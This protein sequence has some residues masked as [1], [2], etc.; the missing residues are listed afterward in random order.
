MISFAKSLL[1][2]TLLT[3]IVSMFIGSS[4]SRGGVLYVHYVSYDGYSA[5]WSWPLFIAGTGL[6][7]V[8]YFVME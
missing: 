6:A 8:I 7:W 3:W 5:Y 4:G 1:P 2:G